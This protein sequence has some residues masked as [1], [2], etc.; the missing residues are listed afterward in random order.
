MMIY[1]FN[2]VFQALIDFSLCLVTVLIKRLSH[3]I[4]KCY[5]TDEKLFA[6][7]QSFNRQ[8]DMPILA[9]CQ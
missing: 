1:I 6:V 3:D 2:N 8:N 5:V 9:A 7:E 4:H